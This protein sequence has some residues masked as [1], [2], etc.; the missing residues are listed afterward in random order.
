M[1]SCS[2]M[3]NYSVLTNPASREAARPADGLD[4]VQ[5]RE[6][7]PP[8]AREAALARAC[9]CEGEPLATSAAK[10]HRR[11]CEEDDGGG[12]RRRRQGALPAK[13]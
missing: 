9:A 2:S 5:G 3:N 1:S 4:L 13:P 12:N 11:P 10:R 6:R 7:E 8:A